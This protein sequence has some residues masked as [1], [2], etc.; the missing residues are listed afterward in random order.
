MEVGQQ[1][2]Q[3]ELLVLVGDVGIVGNGGL[4][5]TELMLGSQL[6]VVH[7]LELGAGDLAQGA[8]EISSHLLSLVDITANRANKLLHNKFLQKFLL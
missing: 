2:I 1:L 3:D 5:D 6:G 7:D 8:A 4:V